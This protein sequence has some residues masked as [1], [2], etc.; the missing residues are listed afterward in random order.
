VKRHPLV[1]WLLVGLQLNNDTGYYQN[2]GHLALYS[3]GSGVG[4]AMVGHLL[5][6]LAFLELTSVAN[7]NF[8]PFDGYGNN[9]VHPSWGASNHP[10][11]A[12]NGYSY[13]DGML[14]PRAGPSGRAVS[15]AIFSTNPQPYSSKGLSVMAAAWGQF[16]AHDMIFT[17]P[18]SPAEHITIPVPACDAHM[19]VTCHGHQNLS[20]HR[21]AWL[22]GSG[23]STGNPRQQVNAATAFIDASTVYG[24]MSSREPVV[25][26]PF[27]CKLLADPVNGVPVNT[28]SASMAGAG[29]AALHELRLTGD[30]RGNENPGL[31]ALHGLMVLEHNRQ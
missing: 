28:G 10:F 9:A 6:W 20:M 21:N 4:V 18:A 3:I 27:S 22:A 2:F 23:T 7:A 19:D 14:E 29:R 26:Q 15:N 13:Q 12:P 16:I 31:L 25:R 8:P 1:V 5:A 30:P 24:Q 11:Y 17:T